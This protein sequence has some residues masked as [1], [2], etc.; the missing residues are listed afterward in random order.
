[1]AVEHIFPGA[2]DTISV[3]RVSLQPDTIRTLM[4]VKQRLRLA[5]NAVKEVLGKE[6]NVGPVE[7][8]NMFQMS[9]VTP[10]V[11]LDEKI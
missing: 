11:E 6:S 4:M 7:V 9:C 10:P 8:S 3:R 5:R 2:H 1:M